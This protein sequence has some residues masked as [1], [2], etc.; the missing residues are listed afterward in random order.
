[1]VIYD[2]LGERYVGVLCAVFASQII[3]IFCCLITY[4]WLFCHLHRSVGFS[5]LVESGGCSLVVVCGLLFVVAS[6]VAVPGL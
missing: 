1:M 2:V 5:L 3:F 6:L 4:L